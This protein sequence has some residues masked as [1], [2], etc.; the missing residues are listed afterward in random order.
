MFAAMRC[1]SSRV[2][3]FGRRAVLRFVVEI[4]IAKRLPGIVAD[5]EAGVVRL[6]DRPGRREAAVCHQTQYSSASRLTAG[7][8]GFLT[9]TQQSCRPGRYGDSSRF[10][11]MPSQ[12]IAGGPAGTIWMDRQSS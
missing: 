12:P 6:L 8:S 2:K 7:A 1:A 10:D 3:N 9:L 5:D 4:E 11:T